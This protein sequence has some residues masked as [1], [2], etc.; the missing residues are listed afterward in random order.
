MYIRKQRYIHKWFLE[1]WKTLWS[2]IF[3]KAY[4]SFG[5]IIL[6]VLQHYSRKQKEKEN[7]RN[8]LTVTL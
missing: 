7:A 6:H 4:N 1:G 5:K 2:D 3:M 8:V